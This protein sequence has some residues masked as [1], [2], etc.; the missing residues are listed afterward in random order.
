MPVYV[1]PAKLGQSGSMA[2]TKSSI[3]K[4]VATFVIEGLPAAGEGGGVTE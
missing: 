2:L 3:E 4:D 1:M